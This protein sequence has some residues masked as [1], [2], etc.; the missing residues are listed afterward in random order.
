MSD[1]NAIKS[2]VEKNGN[3]LKITM[4]Q[5]REAHGSGK[6]GVHVRDA[7]SSILAGMGLGHIPEVLPTYQHE[8]VRLYKK[9]TPVG[10]LITTVLTPGAQNEAKLVEQFAGGVIDYAAIVQQ[11]RELVAV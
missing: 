9:G 5:L 10:D 3:V 2:D 4:E 8:L 7:I 11:I 1:W 6:L